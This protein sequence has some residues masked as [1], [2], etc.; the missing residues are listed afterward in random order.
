MYGIQYLKGDRLVFLSNER[1]ERWHGRKDVA[2]KLAERLPLPSV[3]VV[4]LTSE[5]HMV[6]EGGTEADRKYWERRNRLKKR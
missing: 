1:G 4:P 2:D 5:P 3:R 6:S